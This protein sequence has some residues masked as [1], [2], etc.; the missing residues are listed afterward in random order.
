MIIQFKKKRKLR[1]RI[2]HEKQLDIECCLL[3]FVESLK[4]LNLMIHTMSKHFEE[5]TS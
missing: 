5:E 1:T 3:N 2:S 4:K